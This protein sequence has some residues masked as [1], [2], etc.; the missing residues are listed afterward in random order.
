MG[1][2]VSEKRYFE[3][4]RDNLGIGGIKPIALG[5][6]GL[7]NI[8]RKCRGYVNSGEISISAGDRIAIVTDEDG[9]YTESE[10]RGYA[11]QCRE[12]GY[13]LY[14]SNISFE[15]WLAS[16]FKRLSRPYTQEELERE[17][18]DILGRRYR[19]GE[20]A[21]IDRGMVERAIET[22]DSYLEDVS[23]CIECLARDPSTMVGA[24]MKELIGRP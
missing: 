14:M 17:L 5:E 19:K 20:F 3:D 16:H 22:S 1:D 18:S 12:N 2:G 11:E 23:D 7:R 15:V 21:N 9:R 24:L 13:E 6:T 10:L 4:L 8:I